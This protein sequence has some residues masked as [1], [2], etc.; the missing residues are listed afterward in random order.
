MKYELSLVVRNG[1]FQP[2]SHDI[3]KAD[4]MV[5]LLTQLQI[6]VAIIMERQQQKQPE[7]TLQDDDIPF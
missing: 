6:A 5:S 3:I 2:E 4:S 7:A 1:L